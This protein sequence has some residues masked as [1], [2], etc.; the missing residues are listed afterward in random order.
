MATTIRSNRRTSSP[1]DTPIRTKAARWRSSSSES[2]FRMPMAHLSLRKYGKR[3]KKFRQKRPDPDKPNSWIWNVQGVPAVPYRLPQLIEAVGS[4]QMV[5]I[6]EGEAKVDLLW[7]WNVAA[8]CCAGG[9]GKWRAEHAQYL[10]DVDVI[11]LPDNDPAGRGHVN[12]VAAT[13]QNVA[14]SVRVLELPG[15]Q[16]K[17]DIVDWVAAGGTVGQLR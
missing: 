17:G 11:V 3:K 15:L 5:M 12:T 1:Q 10:R 6:V 2:S 16:P 8:T 14:A 7:S 13:L 9:A 4:K